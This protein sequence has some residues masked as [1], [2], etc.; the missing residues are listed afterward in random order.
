MANSHPASSYL[1]FA[2]SYINVFTE[3]TTV[4]PTDAHSAIYGNMM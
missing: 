3:C 1:T 2:I 4:F